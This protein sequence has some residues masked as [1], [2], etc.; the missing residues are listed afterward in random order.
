MGEKLYKVKELY[1][2]GAVYLHRGMLTR[3]GD[4]MLVIVNVGRILEIPL[5]ARHCHWNL[6]EGLSCRL[7]RIACVALV[8][9]AKEALGISALGQELCGGKCFGVL[10][11]LGKVNGDVNIAVFRICFPFL[12]FLSLKFNGSFSQRFFI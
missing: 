7:A 1:K 5:L 9:V 6:A 3:K 10:F 8:F 11:G 2:G 4:A 12:Q